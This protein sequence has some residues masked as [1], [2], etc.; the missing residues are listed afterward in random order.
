MVYFVFSLLFLLRSCT[1]PQR[2]FYSYIGTR[3]T[4]STTT[5]TRHC[6]FICSPVPAELLQFLLL[7]VGALSY[8]CTVTFFAPLPLF[9]KEKRPC[10]CYC[11]CTRRVCCLGTGFFSMPV[12]FLVH[13]L[14]LSA[15]RR[16]RLVGCPS[17]GPVTQQKHSW[18]GGHPLLF[19]LPCWPSFFEQEKERS[20]L[21]SFSLAGFVIFIALFPTA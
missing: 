10:F 3:S 12:I 13:A 19:D 17:L 7:P 16:G 4:N 9:R 11:W 2:F 15:G 21:L 8:M 6:S 20:C 5:T 14:L 1:R 18:C